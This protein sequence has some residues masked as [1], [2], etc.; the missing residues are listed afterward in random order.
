MLTTVFLPAHYLPKSL[1]RSVSTSLLGKTEIRRFEELKL[2]NG[3]H[4]GGDLES[5]CQFQPQ[6][7]RYD[8]MDEKLTVRRENPERESVIK[9][10]IQRMRDSEREIQ[11]EGE[12][13]SESFERTD[14]LER[15]GVWTLAAPRQPKLANHPN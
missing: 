2:S 3:G 12:R 15:G 8:A 5:V 4:V 1:A 10:K 6:L 11:R 13:D 7:E 9:R 14:R